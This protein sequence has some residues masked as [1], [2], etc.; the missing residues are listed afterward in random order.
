MRL[1]LPLLLL[2]AAFSFGLGL[3]LPLARFEK[4]YFFEET[5][6]LLQIVS[7]LAEGDDWVLAVVIGAFSIVFPAFKLVLLFFTAFGNG[8]GRSL[9]A[10]AA[11]SKWSMMD[12]MV[13]AL[14]IFAAKTTGLAAA[15]TLPGIW[16]YAAATL[17]SAIAAALLGAKR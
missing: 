2:I 9:G 7:G 5:P 15:V 12:V 14:A 6:T 13:V 8:R 10:L 3:T 4:L 1:V 16:F 17:C 11:V